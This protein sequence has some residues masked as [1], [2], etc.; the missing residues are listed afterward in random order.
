MRYDTRDKGFD[1]FLDAVEQGE[2][3]YLESP[4]GNGWLPPRVVDPETGEEDLAEVALPEQGEVLTHTKTHV[5][6]PDFADDAPYT[7]AI[8]SFGPVNV[9]GQ[10]R[11]IETGN[12]EIGQAV[13]LGVE[14]T[15]TT[16]DR[17]LVFYPVE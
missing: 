9:T 15:K 5:A 6:G 10:V 11:N 1:D 16:E 12:I 2:P 13:K 17:V 7:V 3:Y 4:S 8:A 14:R